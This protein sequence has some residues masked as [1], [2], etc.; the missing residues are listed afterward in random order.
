[1]PW[2]CS[3]KNNLHVAVKNLPDDI[4]FKIIP[5]LDLR[6][7]QRL[8]LAYRTAIKIF[9]NED[10][11]CYRLFLIQSLIAETECQF[12][13]KIESLNNKL[14]SNAKRKVAIKNW[15][16]RVSPFVPA[17]SVIPILSVY[18]ATSDTIK[19]D[20]INNVLIPSC[21][22]KWSHFS[23]WFDKDDSCTALF[24]CSAA[25]CSTGEYYDKVA[26]GYF[27][28][29]LIACMVLG[30]LALFSVGF[31][32][33]NRCVPFAL[34]QVSTVNQSFLVKTNPIENMHSIYLQRY[35][36]L[37]LNSDLPE[38]ATSSVEK[39][40]TDLKQLASSISPELPIIQQRINTRLEHSRRNHFFAPRQISIE[41]QTDVHDEKSALLQ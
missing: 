34:E 22:I 36:S 29:L 21:S 23:T 20:F 31:L 11:E 3:S 41:I 10:D 14:L 15:L 9:F 1:M 37:V 7:L 2:P 13:L 26:S 28:G 4:W 32:I 39:I 8:A 35:L 5:F 38:I 18:Y 24:N 25:L 6:E 30:P 40:L 12:N 33:E 17:A 27:L 19:N 16:S